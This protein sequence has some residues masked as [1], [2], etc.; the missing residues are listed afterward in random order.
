MMEN[1]DVPEIDSS[2]DEAAAWARSYDKL[3]PDRSTKLNMRYVSL[4]QKRNGYKKSSWRAIDL[5]TMMNSQPEVPIYLKRD[6]GIALIYEGKAHSFI[7]EFESLKTWA[8]IKL[9]VDAILEGI[10]VMYIDCEGSPGPFARKLAWCG[11]APSDISEKLVY[12]RP[13]DPLVDRQGK[14][15]SGKD[16][17]AAAGVIYEPRIL[18]IDGV[19]EFF[20]IHNL[21]IS[22]AENVA[23]YQKMLLKRFPGYVTTIEIDHVAKTPPEMLGRSRATAIGSEH[24]A[25]GI[26]GS[27]LEFRGMKRGGVG[28]TSTA[29]IYVIKDRE[30]GVRAHSTETGYIGSLVVDENGI[31]LVAASKEE[32]QALQ[33]QVYN[34]I[35]ELPMGNESLARTLTVN[36]GRIRRAT[37]SLE[38]AGLIE[39]GELNKWQITSNQEG[40]RD[41]PP[42]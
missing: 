31:R 37:S 25:A 1:T 34:L 23:T 18:V 26:D 39:R 21:D 24:K 8:A 19:T 36:L 12:I 42:V 32:D 22:R 35:S 17:L 38:R 14:W 28:G 5:S 30:G 4:E 13:E 16:E 40:R 41:L 7:G 29:D 27:I 11:L 2:F 15:T 10:P 20:A 3:G 9:T 33:T 6:D